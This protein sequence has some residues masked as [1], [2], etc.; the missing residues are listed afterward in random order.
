VFCPKAISHLKGHEGAAL[1]EADLVVGV[2]AAL[3][4]VCVK[5][6]GVLEWAALS[7]KL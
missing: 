6:I 4:E 7:E 5:Y 1:F 2:G 3:C